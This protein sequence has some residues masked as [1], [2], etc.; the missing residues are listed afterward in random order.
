MTPQELKDYRIGL[1][2]DCAGWRK[3]ER[4]P[5]LANV[6]TWKMIDAGYKFS[7]A[8]H[9]Y[10][11]M[12]K[13]VTGFLD[14]YKVDILTDAG[15]RNP[16]R[17]P[18]AIGE[19]C[20]YVNDD[21]DVLGVRAYSL[22]EASELTEL[23]QDPDKFTW[24]KMLPRKFPGFSQLKL[25][26]FQR[27]LDEQLAFNNYVFKINGIV[28]NTYGVPPMTSLKCGFPN[29]GIEEMF[30][31]IRGIR[32]TSIDMRRN[33]EE[34]KACVRA[35]DKLYIDPVVARLNA[36]P[37]GPDTNTCFDLGVMLLAHT[38]MS[39]GQWEEFY[40]PSLER[41]LDA[42]AKKKKSVRITVE[43]AIS[44]FFKYFEK[45]PKGILTLDLENDDI[46]K[47]REALPNCCLAG[48]LTA[49]M[50]GRGTKEE[51]LDRI[52][53][54]YKEMDAKNGGFILTTDKFISYRNDANPENLKAVCDYVYNFRF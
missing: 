2:R 49:A 24:E 17:V 35:L 47:A 44:R 1:F 8:L 10:D 25:A 9:D 38:V 46:L 34:L 32:G 7:E 42:A 33:P 29:A 3:P 15:N 30:S 14:K 45:Y 21:R 13:C 28:Q 50:L 52:K 40:W 16:M 19:S 37:E 18:E 5:F 48:G 41:L 22:C 51:C 11:I 4:I 20:Y 26:D 31:M 53:F 54:L 36:A 12:Q 6:V 39:E 43:G 27:V 23:A